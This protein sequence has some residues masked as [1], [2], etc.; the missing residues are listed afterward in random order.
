MLYR[1]DKN[2]SALTCV[3]NIEMCNKLLWLLQI[4]LNFVRNLFSLKMSLFYCIMYT[5]QLQYVILFFTDLS[6]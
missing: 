5:E 4:L 2:E 3:R 1:T 6:M